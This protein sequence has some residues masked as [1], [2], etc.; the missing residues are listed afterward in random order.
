MVLSLECVLRCKEHNFSLIV[1][2]AQHVGFHPRISV[3]EAFVDLTKF[4]CFSQ[5]CLQAV[6]NIQ[7]SI[8]GEHMVIG[9]MVPNDI[10]PVVL[11]TWCTSWD[12]T[13]NAVVSYV[14]PDCQVQVQDT[15]YLSKVICSPKSVCRAMYLSYVIPRGT[16]H[17]PGQESLTRHNFVRFGGWYVGRRHSP[18]SDGWMAPLCA[19][20]YGRAKATRDD[21]RSTR[22]DVLDMQLPELPK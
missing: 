4:P 19:A 8:I 13:R 1:I 17:L 10:P 12:P 3:P 7:L 22:G 2:F 9:T 18:I 15:I 14:R 20:C 21:P 6:R 16:G 5:C 11:C